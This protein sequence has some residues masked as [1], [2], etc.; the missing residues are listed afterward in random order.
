MGLKLNPSHTMFC[1]NIWSMIQTYKPI[2]YLVPITD[3]NLFSYSKITKYIRLNREVNHI[4]KSSCET[5][6]LPQNK[7]VRWDNNKQKSEVIWE[8]TSKENHLLDVAHYYHFHDIT[9]LLLPVNEAS[10]DFDH[11]SVVLTSPPTLLQAKIQIST[12]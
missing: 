2:I 10:A 8:N 7:L 11:P 1:I 5:K 12:G 4:P 6:T 9:G 3:F